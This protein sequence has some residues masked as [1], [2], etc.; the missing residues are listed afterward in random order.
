MKKIL[1]LATGGT[2][3]CQATS[4]GLSPMMSVQD[5]LS[6]IPEAASFCQVDAVSLMNIDSTNMHPDCWIR[7]AEAIESHY[8]E[9]DGF[10]IT[11]GTDTMAYSAAALS[12]LIQNSPK[13]IILTGS[14][15]PISEKMTDG[16][17]NLLDSL[18]FACCPKACGVTVV[19]GGKIILGTRARKINTKSF[20]AF[21]SINFPNVGI[22]LQDR[23]ILYMDLPSSGPV[24]FYHTMDP[25]VFVMKLT[26]GVDAKVL[27]L[28]EPLFHAFIL[29]SYGV[30]GIPEGPEY[31]FRPVLEELTSHGSIIVLTT[32]AIY[33]G[34]DIGIYHSGH[35]AKE[36]YGLMEAY[37]MTLEATVTKLMWILG[38]T[39]D[40]QQIRR[41][42][43]TTIANDMLFQ[44]A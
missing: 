44:H 3:A 30:G 37:D 13:P 31:H 23:V 25:K 34:S 32:Q 38:Q 12:Y 39:R 10:V 22:I 36:K 33:E 9:Y 4:E 2:I 17:T 5:M 24:R 15:R 26:P 11:H 7:M 28:C 1:L 27:R 20:D 41:M 16:R 42:F 19:F 35:V 14:Q 29:E 40:P 6:Y 8:T 43:N 18:R 21:G